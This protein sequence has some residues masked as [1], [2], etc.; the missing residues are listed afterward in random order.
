MVRPAF[1]T[2]LGLVLL[3]A[4][5]RADHF[6][7]ELEVKQKDVVK[8]AQADIAAL[9][10]KPK[11]RPSLEVKVGVPVTA[12]WTLSYTADKGK[13]KNVVVHFFVVK[14]E[15]AGQ[16]TIPRLDKD[17]WVETALTM[18]F[19]PKE[20]NQG[21]L[22]FTI[23]KPGVYLLR[24]E[25]IGAAAGIDGHEHFSSLDLVIRPEEAKP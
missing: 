10:V 13:V 9:G 24:V 19:G 21:D 6:A 15:Q 11:P 12:K 4:A 22:T 20:K 17:V 23:D 3:G 18:D 8:K 16:A 7:V 1:L 2:W 5:A 25:T 14:E